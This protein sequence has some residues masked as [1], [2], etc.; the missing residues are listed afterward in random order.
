MDTALNFPTLSPVVLAKD[1]TVLRD[2]PLAKGRRS[3][4]YEDAF[5]RHTLIYDVFRFDEHHIC[6]ICPRL[7]NLKAAFI[8]SL[9]VNGTSAT[10][11]RHKKSL[12]Y[13]MFIVKCSKQQSLSVNFLGQITQ[14][15][16]QQQADT[17]DGMNVAMTMVK[18]TPPE[19]I[20]DWA[21]YHV[22]AHGLEGLLLFDNGSTE[23]E[24]ISLGKRLRDESGLK[25]VSIV[26]APFRYGGRAGGKFV[27]P[28]MYLQVS[29]MHIARHRFLNASKAVLSLDIDELVAPLKGKTIFEA[30][31]TSR[32]GFAHIAGQW[33]YP[34]TN[35]DSQPHKSH[36]GTNPNDKPCAPKWCMARGGLADRFDWAVHRPAGP[37]YAFSKECGKFWH[38][39]AT[40]KSWFGDRSSVPSTV[41]PNRALEE[42]LEVYLP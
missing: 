39:R 15:E 41:V 10:I 2:F 18:D 33:V 12:R 17:F 23:Y 22:S 36:A 6:C 31:M 42:A 27:A 38:F 19:W 40:S 3:A 35:G 1:S 4:K 7:L 24:P 9:Q 13:E 26:S 32:F 11:R 25:A 30:A 16:V 14:I 28:A 8:K 29:L 20:V 37:L 21:K 5:D 34:V